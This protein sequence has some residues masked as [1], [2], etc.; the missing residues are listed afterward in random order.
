VINDYQKA[1]QKCDA[2]LSPISP[3]VASKLG[4]LIS[5]PVKNMMADIY[6]VTTNTAGIPSLALPG[7]FTQAKLPVGFQLQGKM[8][9]ENLLLRLGYHYQQLTKWHLQRPTL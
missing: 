7:G 5:D 9:S 3:T 4:E 6:T 2:I 1:F 8:F